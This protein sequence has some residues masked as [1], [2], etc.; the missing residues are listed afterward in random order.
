NSGY[1]RDRDSEFA[2]RNVHTNVLLKMIADTRAV[3]AKAFD[4]MKEEDLVKKYPL[5]TFGGERDTA[6][7]LLTL[8]SHLN[9]HLGQINYLRRVFSPSAM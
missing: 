8:I 1:V 9:Y 3:V 7:V 6:Y 2:S 5:E 4:G